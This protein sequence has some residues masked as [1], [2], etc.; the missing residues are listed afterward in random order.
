MLSNVLLVINFRLIAANASFFGST[1]Q[2]IVGRQVARVR[3]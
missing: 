3:L 2:A 1:E